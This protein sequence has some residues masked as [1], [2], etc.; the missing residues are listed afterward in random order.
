[1]VSVGMSGAIMNLPEKITLQTQRNRSAR[2]YLN[3]EVGQ[4]NIRFL[5]I[6]MFRTR[7]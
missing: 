4:V 2:V 1:V 5:S 7:F 3:A 6:Q